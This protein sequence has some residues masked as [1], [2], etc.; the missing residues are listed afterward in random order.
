M[1]RHH[2]VFTAAG[3]YAGGHTAEMLRLLEKLNPACYAP[4]CYI[5]A[6]TDKMGAQH[7]LAAEQRRVSGTPQVAAVSLKWLMYRMLGGL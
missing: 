1:Q 3:L 5:V 7:A 4:R 2:Y 6:A